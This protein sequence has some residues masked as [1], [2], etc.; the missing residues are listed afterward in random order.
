MNNKIDKM[1]KYAYTKVPMYAKIYEK[2]FYIR[3]ILEK[4]MLEEEFGKLPLITKEKILESED[5]FS[6]EYVCNRQN[7]MEVSTSGSTGKCIKIE[8]NKDEYS[9]SLLKLWI[10]RWKY[11][12]INTN[13][14]LC[15]FYTTGNTEKSVMNNTFYEEK[16]NM[17]GF[18]KSSLSDE[19]MMEI[20]NKLLEFKPVWMNIQ[21]SIAMI[22]ANFIEQNRLESI[23][24]L[25]YIEFTGEM[26][27]N[28]VKNKVKDVFKCKVANQYGCYEANSIAYECP[29]GNM[30][31]MDDNVYVEIID[32]DGKN[33]VEEEGKVII[34]T[35]N[36]HAMPFIRYEVGDR[37]KLHKN[38]KCECGNK[39]H[40][41]EL[42][43]GRIC[44]YAIM[45]D[46][47]K[48]NSY[49]FVRAIDKV[50]LQCSNVIRQFQIIQKDFDYFLVNLILDDDIVDE[51]WGERIIED[52]FLKSITE[53]KL[54][55]TE[56][57]FEYFDKF[58]LDSDNGKLRY[59]KR[60][61]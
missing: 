20:Y 53:E 7:I 50:N 31:C 36:N 48:V 56:F 28:N 21:P 40:I 43:S 37:G 10:L 29:C 35:L 23:P 61:I 55:D 46:G 54:Y 32:N 44:D 9:R 39:S 18:S 22:F 12:G 58:S 6:A 14:K 19:R 16:D 11:Y 3:E 1:V 27:F 2:D 17:I 25:R 30:H 13:D 8:W 49:V 34:T 4:N 52:V 38:V 42:K 57:E 41:L 5:F 51:G 59:F 26:L 33:V 15:F 47:S 60:E 24:S 45:K